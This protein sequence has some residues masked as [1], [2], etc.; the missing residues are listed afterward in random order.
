VVDRRFEPGTILNIQIEYDGEELPPVL[1]AR[2]VH[3]TAESGGQWA[4]GCRFPRELTEKD[5]EVIVRPPA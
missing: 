1:L 2:V 4:L 3:V 5:L